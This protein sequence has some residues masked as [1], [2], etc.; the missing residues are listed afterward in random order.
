MTYLTSVTLIDVDEWRK[1]D[2]EGLAID[3]T[4]VIYEQFDSVI[5]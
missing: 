5:I 2:S 4:F 1:L 3:N